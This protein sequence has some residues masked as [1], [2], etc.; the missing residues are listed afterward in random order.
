[1]LVY[2]HPQK[3]T[4]VWNI[5]Q[6]GTFPLNTDALSLSLSFS[7][8]LSLSLSLSHT[9]IIS[10]FSLSPCLSFLSCFQFF[11]LSL[12]HTHPFPVSSSQFIFFL[13]F[14][15]TKSVEQFFVVC[16]NVFCI[17]LCISFYIFFLTRTTFLFL[18]KGTVKSRVYRGIAAT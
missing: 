10:I 1:M 12:S 7:L 9:H 14:L 13:F 8:F 18:Q 15:L 3:M 16:I 2:A 4:K 6:E 11:Y 5:D 17:S